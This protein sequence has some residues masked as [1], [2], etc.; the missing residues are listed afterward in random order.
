VPTATARSHLLVNAKVVTMLTTIQIT[1]QS[2]VLASDLF[3]VPSIGF[4]IC[5]RLKAFTKI[6]DRS[7]C[8][9]L[10]R[11]MQQNQKGGLFANSRDY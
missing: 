10:I 5:N 7:D 9:I 8:E 4:T 1:R 6:F 3:L 2:T 11:L